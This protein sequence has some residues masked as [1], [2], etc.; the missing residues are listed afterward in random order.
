[1]TFKNH[2]LAGIAG[3]DA[4]FGGNADLSSIVFRYKAFLKLLIPTR[5][6]VLEVIF[7]LYAQN[8]PVTN[9]FG[10]FWL[11][12]ENFGFVGDPAAGMCAKPQR[13]S[14]IS[15]KFYILLFIFGTFRQNSLLG[16]EFASG[17]CI[18]AP[19]K[20]RRVFFKIKAD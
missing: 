8:C 19:K 7:G 15:A 20:T 6:V 2:Y 18:Y 4:D 12:Y 14:N 3:S 1:M 17:P 5:Y 11:I 9:I 16:A 13:N 10:I